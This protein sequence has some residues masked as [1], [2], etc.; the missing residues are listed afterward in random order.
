MKRVYLDWGVVSSLKKPE[1]FDVKEFLLT[2]KKDLFFV[3]SSAH[4]QDAMRSKDNARLTQDVEMLEDLVDDHFLAYN[5]KMVRPYLV[6]PTVYYRENKGR[7]LDTIPDICKAIYPLGDDMPVI[8]GIVKLMT[9][10]PFSIPEVVRQDKMFQ[11]AFPELPA[12]PSLMDVI[13][14]CITFINKLQRNRN[15]YKKYRS[16]LQSSGF[17]VDSNSGNW[18]SDEVIPNISEFLKSLGIDKTFKELVLTGFENEEKVDNFRFFISAYSL[19]DLIGY[20]SDKLSKATSAMNSVTTD[21]QHAYYAAFCDYLITLDTR[22]ASKAQALYRELGVSTK[23]ISPAI[24]FNELKEDKKEAISLFLKEQLREEHIESQ[25]DRAVVYKFDHRFLGIFSHCIVYEQD[26]GALIEFKLAFDN[27]S[28]FIF[29]GEAGVMVDTVS[30]YLGLPLNCNYERVRE[31]IVS[32]DTSASINWPGDGIHLM[33][34]A[35]SERHR[36][37]LLISIQTDKN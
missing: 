14:S 32:G 13:Q 19:L 35:D 11:I 26:D 24:V 23:I 3:Y 20:K 34:R 21:A 9:E 16:E 6:T 27:Y 33:L 18:S 8:G 1:F 37:E 31:S 17:K 12:S 2:R 29:Y 5:S 36:P 10:W 15:Y 22:L 4:F 25:Y 7:E 30:E 28:R